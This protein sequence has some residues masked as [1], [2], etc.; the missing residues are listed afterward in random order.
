MKINLGPS[1]HYLDGRTDG[2][3]YDSTLCRSWNKS[4]MYVP[5]ECHVLF[6]STKRDIGDSIP[7]INEHINHKRQTNKIQDPTHA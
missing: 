5:C 1:Q 4:N 7:S 6:L 2:W 3:R